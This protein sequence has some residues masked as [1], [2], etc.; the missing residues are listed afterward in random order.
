[1]EIEKSGHS[2]HTITNVAV[3]LKGNKAEVESYGLT[4]GGEIENNSIKNI[5]IFFGRY[6]DEFTD[7][8]DGWKISKRL[9][10]LD[11]NFSTEAENVSGALEGLFLGMNL[12]TD[13]EKYR[14][15]YNGN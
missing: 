5:N 7:T 11:S 13:S 3:E 14:K 8:P 15:L 12:R 6:H 9:Y 2:W 1:M 10:I 4:A